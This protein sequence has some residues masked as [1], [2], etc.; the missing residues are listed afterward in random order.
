MGMNGCLLYSV[1]GEVLGSWRDSLGDG[2]EEQGVF[3]GGVL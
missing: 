1:A 3:M 2:R